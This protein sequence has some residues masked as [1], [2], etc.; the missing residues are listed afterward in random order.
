VSD[1]PRT[2][3]R[4]GLRASNRDR[5]GVPD[6]L[7]TSAS[8]TWRLLLLL[9][10]GLAVLWLLARLL[11]VTLPVTVA[12]IVATLAVPPTDWLRRRGWRDA[13][14]TAIVVIGGLALIVGL[15]AVLT[16]SFV[17]QL[18]E[19][20][21][22]LADAWDSVL[23]WL[24]TGPLGYDRARVEEL[25]G[26]LRSAASSGGGGNLVSGVLSGAAIVA[27]SLAGILL[28]VV[29]L[30]FFVKDGAEI[31][32]WFIDRTA[33]AHRDTVRAVGTRAWGALGG[34]V[35]GTALIALIDALGIGIGLLVLGV[36]LV[37]PLTLLVFLGG[38]LP[39]IGAFAAGLIAVLVALAA[40]GIVKALL[41]LAVILGVQQLEGNLLQPV[42]MRRAVAL[43]P[44]VILAALGAGAA[45]AG[46]V[47]A[48]LSVPIAAV[49]AAVG[50]ELRLRSEADRAEAIQHEQQVP[51]PG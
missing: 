40:G 48:F 43:H 44:V 36:P 51:N 32:Q 20:G 31:V 15:L 34:Y 22:T 33:P 2:A 6:W 27:Q 8:W 4:R 49:V 1:A 5:S 7:E 29:L 3:T 23:D 46:I 21:P 11:V 37:G 47:G 38:F 45:L 26:S 24:E 14:A 18:S 50:N 39:V 30:F 28:F 25:M 41:V 35:R 9:V 19:L 16:P 12:I 13:P 17:G 42:I 10:A